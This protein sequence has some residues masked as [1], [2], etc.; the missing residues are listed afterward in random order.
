MLSAGILQTRPIAAISGGNP[1][2]V[3]TEQLARVPLFRDVPKASLKRLARLARERNYAQGETIFNEGDEGVGFFLISEGEATVTRGGTELTRLGRDDFFGEMALL[4][5][6]RRS[7]TVQAA[8]PLKTFAMLRSDFVAELTSNSELVM[9]MLAAMS[10]RLRETDE[11]FA[12][13]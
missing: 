1:M 8:T 13:I 10:H 3:S 4:E 9:S 7:A 6:R 2:T 5:H 12:G 11:A